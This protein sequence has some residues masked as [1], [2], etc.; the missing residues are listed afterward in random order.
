MSAWTLLVRPSSRC[1]TASA[2]SSDVGRTWVGLSTYAC[3]TARDDTS[4]RFWDPD[5]VRCARL[6]A[7]PRAAL[8][9]RSRRRYRRRRRGRHRSRPPRHPGGGQPMLAHQGDAAVGLTEVRTGAGVPEGRVDTAPRCA[10]E[11][12]RIHRSA[13]GLD[14]AMASTRHLLHL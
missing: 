14:R 11:P 9:D 13:A 8:D 6:R 2:T 1:R 4:S 12:A 5:V 3:A 10:D 7:G